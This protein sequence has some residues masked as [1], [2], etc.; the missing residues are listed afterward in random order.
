M[1]LLTVKE[2]EART[3]LTRVTLWRMEREGQFPRRR[4]VTTRNV[5]WIDAEVDEWI[6]NLPKSELK[7]ATA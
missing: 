1:K 3:G 5:R 2:V 7:E 4:R 6:E